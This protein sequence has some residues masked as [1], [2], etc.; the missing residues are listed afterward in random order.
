MRAR[1]NV[2]FYTC[3]MVGSS[4]PY[5]CDVSSLILIS[6]FFLAMHQC[7]NLFRRRESVEQVLGYRLSVN[8]NMH[9]K[10]DVNKTEMTELQ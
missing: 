9:T 5:N 7:A 10:C 4:K 1:S 3:T 2:D 6:L 8:K